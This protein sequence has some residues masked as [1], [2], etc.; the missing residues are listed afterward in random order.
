M[1]FYVLLATERK[2][3]DSTYFLGV[4]KCK[5]YFHV[6]ICVR[7]RTPYHTERAPLFSSV[8]LFCFRPFCAK[9]AQ[10]WPKTGPNGRVRS[11]VL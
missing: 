7:R 6:H 11:G 1:P 9:D 10:K 4:Q 8:P 5:L 2:C 3:C